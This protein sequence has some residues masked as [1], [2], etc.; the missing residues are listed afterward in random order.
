MSPIRRRRYR[1]SE[2]H[3][4]LYR[5]TLAF[6]AACSTCGKPLA[7]APTVRKQAKPKRARAAD[8]QVTRAL[9][10]ALLASVSTSALAADCSP[11]ADEVNAKC[12]PGN[13]Q[14]AIDAAISSDRPLILP[15][16]TYQGPVTIDYTA[17]AGTG[18]EL[19]SRGA[20]IEG[21]LTIQCQSECFY[22]HQEGTLF[23]SGRQPGYLVTVGKP[24]LSDA[25]NS[26]KLDHLIVNNG[27]GPAVQLNYVLNAQA[28]V[29]ADSG[30]G[31]GLTLEQVQFS[32]IAGAA[33]GTVAALAVENG[34][35][36]SDEFRALDLEASPICWLLTSTK[37]SHMAAISTYMNCPVEI[38]T[39]HAGW[40]AWTD[41]SDG[42]A[43]MPG[44][45]ASA[46]LK[47]LD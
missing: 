46:F 47:W 36:F 38:A 11:Q 21:G 34:Y 9:A 10:G 33:S 28:F 2:G 13:L 42:V 30:A 16:G 35:S 20:T 45:A 43:G 29:V 44:G 37:A 5:Q 12:Y 4:W 17:H 18:F 14:A 23:V 22:F 41:G 39:T 24:D 8:P 3:E 19:I 25:Q 6:G 7:L 40:S 32:S 27:G 1:C 31:I 15:R 26:I